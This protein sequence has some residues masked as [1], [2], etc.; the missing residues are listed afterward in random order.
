[1]Y[2]KYFLH[3]NKEAEME[4]LADSYTML[5]AMLN[6]ITYI[7]LMYFFLTF[8]IPYVSFF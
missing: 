6:I 3:L 2:N 1:M 4:R 5:S 8:I 7:S